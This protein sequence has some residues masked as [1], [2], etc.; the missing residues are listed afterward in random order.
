MRAQG[1]FLKNSATDVNIGAWRRDRCGLSVHPQFPVR[2]RRARAPFAKHR[3]RHGRIYRAQE[4]ERERERL[5][6][7]FTFH[8]GPPQK[9]IVQIKEE[10][11]RE[12]GR[13]WF[14]ALYMYVVCLCGGGA[15]LPT[16]PPP[17][18]PSPLGTCTSCLRM[19]SPASCSLF[20][21][22]PN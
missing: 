4:R 3:R 12:G 22:W 6:A 14:I 10:E 18:L 1:S 13:F 21:A 5:G 7:V 11:G 15:H 9:L 19:T 8:V 2:A 16:Q 17:P 20:P